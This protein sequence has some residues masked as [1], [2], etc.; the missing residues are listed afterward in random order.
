M[1]RKKLTADF[2]GGRPA[3]DGGVMLLA[4]AECRMR[5]ADRLARAVEVKG[6]GP[7]RIRLEKIENFSAASLHGF[8]AAN[9]AQGTTIK[10]DGWAYPGAPGV[11]QLAEALNARRW[12]SSA[13]SL[14]RRT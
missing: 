11:N 12:S 3:S 8:V 13:H 7:G 1:G 14:P 10:T 6:A 5:I 2:Y 4:M 9:V